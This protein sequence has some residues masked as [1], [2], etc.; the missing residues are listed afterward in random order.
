MAPSVITPD[1]LFLRNT[2]AVFGIAPTIMGV[3]AIFRPRGGLGLLKFPAPK[4]PEAQRLVDNLIRIFDV[5]DNAIGLSTLV[6]WYL[7]DRRVLGWLMV[8][9]VVVPCVDGWTARLQLEKGAEWMHLPFAV[10]GL[11]LGGGLLGWFGGQGGDS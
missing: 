10:V 5:R 11:G 3:Y 1:S 2:T 7:A 6:A 4:D 8:S 9:Q